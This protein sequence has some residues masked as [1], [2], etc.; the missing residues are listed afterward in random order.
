MEIPA[1]FATYRDERMQVTDGFFNS[2]SP[3]AGTR[4]MEFSETVSPQV[5]RQFRSP[6]LMI[7]CNSFAA[8]EFSEKVMKNLRVPGA[9]IWFMTYIATVED[10]FDSF[11]RDADM[12]FGPT[13]FIESD[14]ELKDICNVSDSFVPVVFVH[15]GKAVVRKRV[16][17]DVQTVLDKLVSYGFYRNC[18]LD[19]EDSLDGY[20][21]SI[22][23]SDYPSTIPFVSNPSRIQGFP[24]VIT[25]FL[26]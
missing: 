22:I 5:N 18:V 4:F 15:Q 26:L 6:M 2:I 20:T 16:S 1:F 13:H 7:D 23:A 14:S 24:A 3:K 17:A 11:N 9:D 8:R 10:V 12:V 19:M 25:P 21:W